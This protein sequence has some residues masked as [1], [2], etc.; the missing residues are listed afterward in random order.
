MIAGLL[1]HPGD[2]RSAWLRTFGLHGRHV[3][4]RGG[5]ATRSPRG[6]VGKH[7]VAKAYRP[8]RAPL[9]YRRDAI[10]ALARALFDLASFVA[11]S[12][13]SWLAFS[14]LQG[15]TPWS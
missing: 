13:L 9:L 14:L 10:G 8:P 6:W 7:K 3:A 4:T 12:A 2:W 5:L 1:D 15:A 11:A